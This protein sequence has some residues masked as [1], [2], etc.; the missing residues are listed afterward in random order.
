MLIFNRSRILVRFNISQ[1]FGINSW[2]TRYIYTHLPFSKRRS[3]PLLLISFLQLSLMF[4]NWIKFQPNDFYWY[5]NST[6]RWGED[7]QPGQKKWKARWKNAVPTSC[8]CLSFLVIRAAKKKLKSTEVVVVEGTER[9]R[10][11]S[12]SFVKI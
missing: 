1:K 7:E 10:N 11:R 4:S 2:I 3:N 12:S 9:A 8:R 6:A 5:F